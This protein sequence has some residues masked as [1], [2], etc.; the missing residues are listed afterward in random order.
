M[1]ENE[2]GRA[3]REIR[4]ARGLS[5]QDFTSVVSREHISRLERGVSQP[6]LEVVEGLAAVLGVHPISL[7]AR[8]Y[9]L[10]RGDSAQLSELFRTMDHDLRTIRMS[11]KG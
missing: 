10:A 8:S 5:Q 2:F 9:Q 1:A 11:S 6:N 4:L 7:L 3:L